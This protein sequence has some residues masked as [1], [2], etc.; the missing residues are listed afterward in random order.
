MICS[1]EEECKSHG[2]SEVAEWYGDYASVIYPKYP[3]YVR[4]GYR[5]SDKGAGSFAFGITGGEA[6]SI[7]TFRL[8]LT[9]N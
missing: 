5:E 1:N 7:Y 8:V 4:G 2:L 6:N 3:W 9:S